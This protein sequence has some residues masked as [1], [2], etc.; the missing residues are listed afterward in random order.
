MQPPLNDVLTII[1]YIPIWIGGTLNCN[2][3]NWFLHSHLVYFHILLASFIRKS[4]YSNL[5]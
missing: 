2:A 3:L 4:M 5:L 1:M